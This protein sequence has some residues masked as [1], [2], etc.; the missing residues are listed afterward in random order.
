MAYT[1]TYSD[2]RSDI[3][4]W[5]DVNSA[6]N[7]DFLAAIDTIIDMA[8]ERLNRDASC[9]DQFTFDDRPT[10]AGVRTI[11]VSHL[12][13]IEVRS[14]HRISGANRYP[15][16]RV[17]FEGFFELYPEVTT[18]EVR[19]YTLS[20]DNDTIYLGP[21]PSAALTIRVS[22]RGGITPLDSVN[23][24]NWWTRYAYDLLLSCCLV[25]AARFQFDPEMIALNEGTYQGRLRQHNARYIDNLRDAAR[26]ASVVVDNSPSTGE[27]TNG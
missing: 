15:L 7:T 22:Y 2:L 11:D 20:D 24:R 4:A 23:T 26:S 25:E 3:A 1:K 13:M 8:E 17:S 6:Q 21:A 9:P 5:M 19:Y 18:G 14:A 16:R 27:V 12:R 10:T